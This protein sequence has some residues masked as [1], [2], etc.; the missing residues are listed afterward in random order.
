MPGL[1]G[2]TDNPFRDRSDLVRAA[3]TLIQPLKPYKSLAGAR[4]K[5]FPSTAPA[6][7][8]V[9][10][11]LEGFARPLWAIATMLGGDAGSGNLIHS[12]IE[13]IQ[14]GVD[15]SSPEYWGDLGSF[16]QR[17]VEMEPIAFALLTAP[18]AV[19][20]SL[21]EESKVNLENWLRQ[22]N[23]HDMP[24][25]NWRWFRILVNLALAKVLGV[26]KD[27]VSHMMD[28]D[29]AILDQFYL[30]EGWSSD[31]VW[32]DERK[33]ADYYSGSFA[34][35][36]AQLLY[37]RFADGDEVRVE[38]YR[39]QAIGFASQYWRYF[40]VN[41][42]AIPFGRSMT[43]RFACGA[44]WAA[45]ALVDVPLSSPLGSWGSI[46]GMLLRH[47]RWWSKQAEIFNSDG[48][49]TIGFTYPNMYLSEDYNSRQSVYWC[50][51][52]FIVLSL[53]Q[54]HPF[55]TSEEEPHPM[56]NLKQPEC[57]NPLHVIWST[58]HI[59]CNSPEHHFLLSS[60]QM[61]T[62]KFKA[63]EA[64]YGKFAY[65]SAF[66]FSVPT[67][68]EL[69]QLAPDST[70]SI[71]LDDGESWKVRWQPFR[72]RLQTVLVQGQGE[73]FEIP[74]I[75]SIW[76]PFKYLDLEIETTLASLSPQFPGWHI[77]F[78]K[79]NGLDSLKAVPWSSG[80]QLVDASFAVLA[81]SATGYHVPKISE[82]ASDDL[83]E[84]CYSENSSILV[85]SQAGGSGA[86]NLTD[87]AT[88]GIDEK[89]EGPAGE[90]FLIEA[91]PN[92]NL[93]AQRTFIP[94][95]RYYIK[96]S[97]GESGA[98]EKPTESVLFATGIFGVSGHVDA[99]G[100]AEM[101]K[102]RPTLRLGT[103]TKGNVL[104]QVS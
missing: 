34:I 56:S 98:T 62:R 54:D 101:W 59:L 43:Y 50:L 70:L 18:D 37:V 97:Q 4:V 85:S 53:P 74:A 33:Q 5:L 10:A 96:S 22:I 84:G 58:R 78:H 47:L 93:I 89:V 42:A 104:V 1:A 16:D 90:A 12:W 27:Q 19:L 64:K 75:S 7:D 83:S 66:G 2:F 79:V 14:V 21:N 60:G 24:R 76:K 82:A 65:S 52:S 92:T 15:P 17:M 46:K 71:S 51:K 102:K 8:D 29:F 36:F 49:L 61:T 31:G 55:W 30:G 87:L 91:D 35:Q 41:G 25:N 20:R 69:H 73:A 38:R 45:L 94:S 3:A 48:T 6:F 77:R 99:D 100:M 26:P 23:R 63:R 88:A 28:E 80:I 72:I 9:A 81:L 11:Q 32:G 67:G 57:V 103:D 86:V 68:P 13:G 39:Q 95:I 40:D 44:F